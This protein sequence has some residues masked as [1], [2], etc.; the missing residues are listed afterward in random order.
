MSVS[1]ESA[2]TVTFEPEDYSPVRIVYRL[3]TNCMEI[4]QRGDIIYIPF[5][6]APAFLEA[7]R[8]WVE[9]GQ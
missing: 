3:D 2:L 1:T 9:E 6:D 8:K 4:K 5:D 7:V